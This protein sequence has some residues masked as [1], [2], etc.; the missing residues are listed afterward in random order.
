MGTRYELWVNGKQKTNGHAHPS[1]GKEDGEDLNDQFEAGSYGR[2]TLHCILQAM[3]TL[4]FLTTL[5][6]AVL[7]YL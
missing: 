4:R 6:Y 3:F 7:P 5:S 2:V 1:Q